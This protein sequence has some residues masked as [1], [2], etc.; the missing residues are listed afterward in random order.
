[1]KDQITLHQ[2][3]N[4]NYLVDIVGLMYLLMT[5]E[6]FD[7][8]EVRAILESGE[9][10]PYL[11][12]VDGESSYLIAQDGHDSLFQLDD[13]TIHAFY[14]ID[15][16][17]DNEPNLSHNRSNKIDYEQIHY[18]EALTRM[19][20]GETVYFDYEDADMEI[21]NGEHTFSPEVILDALWFTSN[22]VKGKK[23]KT[24]QQA[25]KN[26]LPSVDSIFDRLENF[27]LEEEVKEKK[28]KKDKKTK[29]KEKKPKKK[30]PSK[31]ELEME[32]LLDYLFSEDA[33]AALSDQGFEIEIVD[34]DDIDFDDLEDYL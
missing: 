29:K 23:P 1:M 30:A 16:L 25:P 7:Q 18:E 19:K 26:A 3:E 34:L 32:D 13:E 20:N 11:V 6:L 28:I 10:L 27:L 17:N 5:N 9:E 4:G 2:D 8:S 31:T 15:M 12:C 22:G 33:L 24:L 21:V 14:E